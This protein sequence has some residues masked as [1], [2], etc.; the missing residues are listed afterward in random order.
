VEKWRSGEVEKWRSGEVEKWRSGE[1]EKWRREKAKGKRQKAKGP[2]FSGLPT[3]A[4]AQVGLRKKRG[5]CSI[6]CVIDC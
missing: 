5:K 4:L 1:V 3:E 2:E 6:K